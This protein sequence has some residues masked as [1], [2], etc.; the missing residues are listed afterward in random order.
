MLAEIW[1]GGSWAIQ[2]APDPAGASGSQLND[3]SC[4][5]AS[6]CVAVGYVQESEGGFS[7]T[8]AETWDGSN[9]TTQRTANASSPQSGVDVVSDQ[10]GGVWCVS[11][12]AC[13][14]VGTNS[15]HGLAEHWD[16][17]AW[18]IQ[19]MPDAPGAGTSVPRAVACTS[20]DTC[21]AVGSFQ[22]RGADAPHPL[23]E[24]WSSGTWSAQAAATSARG[25]LNRVACPSY[26]IAVG[27]AS[28]SDGFTE[29]FAEVFP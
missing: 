17:S 7:N 9:W 19:S 24:R 10:L 26:C 1:N 5:S 25:Q 16:G 12:S 3:V 27:S 15:D 20:A 21:E 13:T 29:P 18:T 2:P 28:A 6:A 14:A 23:Q 8:L 22:G 11:A 4:I